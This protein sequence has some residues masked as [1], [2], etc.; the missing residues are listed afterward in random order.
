[1][2]LGQ[3]LINFVALQWLEVDQPY[4]LWILRSMQ[5]YRYKQFGVGV[6]EVAEYANYVSCVTS[7]V[8]LHKQIP[9]FTCVVSSALRACKDIKLILRY[10]QKCLR[11]ALLGRH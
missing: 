8:Y 5:V 3:V 9:G 11:P 6:E 10:A 4:R 1:V 7:E 2:A